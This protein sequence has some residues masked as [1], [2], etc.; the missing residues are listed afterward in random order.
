MSVLLIEPFGGLAGDMLL[1]ALLDL[2]DERFRMAELEAVAQ[3]LVPGEFE[4]TLTR[5][6]RGG[7]AASHLEVSTPESHHPPH[8]HLADLLPLIERSELSDASKA[9]ASAVLVRIAEAEAQVHGTTVDA[10]HFHEVGAVDTLIDVCGACHAFELLGVTDVHASAPITGAGTVRCA[11]GE[12]PVPVPAVVELLRGRE[13]L[14]GGGPGERLTPTGAALLAEWTQNFELPAQFAASTTGYGAGT[15]EPTEGPPNL[16]RLQLANEGASEVRTRSEVC[17]LRVTLD[18]MTGEEI[19]YLVGAL[20]EHG[21]LEVW[22]HAV[23]MKKNRPG[24]VLTLL[25]RE[26]G[27]ADL[28]TVIFNNSTSFG[29][30]WST[31]QRTECERETQRIELLGSEIRI[32][33]RRRPGV[34]AGATPESGDVHPE[35]DDLARLAESTGRNLAELRRLAID[36]V[37]RVAK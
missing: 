10:I 9:R 5:T 31:W 21:A 37:T 15:R 16:V 17:E 35:H 19:G 3:S 8:R 26:E 20:R 30:R 7:L 4:L 28:E 14:L 1:A 22:T 27:R 24:T 18:D 13:M 25:C 2:G 33:L 23:Q 6:K 11:H 36:A 34:A 12:M 32:K 29:L